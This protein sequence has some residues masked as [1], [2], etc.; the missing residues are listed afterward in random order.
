MKYLYKFSTNEFLNFTEAEGLT[1]WWIYNKEPLER[2]N[3]IKNT[4]YLETLKNFA[5]TSNITPSNEEL[6]SWIDNIQMIYSSLGCA[7]EILNNKEEITKVLDKIQIIAE[8]HIPYSNARA[9]IIM[10]KDNKILI[11]ELSYKKEYM[12]RKEKY[13]EKLNQVMY[14]KELLEN[15]LPRHLEIAT[16]SFPIEPETD[17]YGN[18]EKVNSKFTKKKTFK[19]FDS[20]YYLGKYIIDFFKHTNKSALQELEEIKNDCIIENSK[21]KKFEKK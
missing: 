10:T 13:E 1:N 21:D 19:N 11:I 14:Y 12:S 15:T 4:T 18:P 16:Y 3:A 6:I 9:D 7:H 5:K 20:C 8:Y 17:K 2:F